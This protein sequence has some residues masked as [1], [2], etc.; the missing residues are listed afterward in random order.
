MHQESTH[1]LRRDDEHSKYVYF[2]LATTSAALGFTLEKHAQEM[3]KGI[4][5]PY[6]ALLIAMISWL[7]SFYSGLRVIHTRLTE[8]NIAANVEAVQDLMELGKKKINPNNFTPF[9]ER[10]NDYISKSNDKLSVTSSN[11]NFYLQLQFI[12]LAVGAGAYTA[13]HLL[14][15]FV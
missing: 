7:L 3:A 14:P 12:F 6:L 8:L 13:F 4:T 1:S 15:L 11:F 2:V 5:I 9:I 10:H